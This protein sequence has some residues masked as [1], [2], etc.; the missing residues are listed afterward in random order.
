M[1][2]EHF[3]GL[4]CSEI[5]LTYN[6]LYTLYIKEKGKFVNKKKI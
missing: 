5:Q 4:G 1:N 3:F 2:I 6:I